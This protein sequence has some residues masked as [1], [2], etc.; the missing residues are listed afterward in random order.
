[1]AKVPSFLLGA[2]QL[3]NPRREP[4]RKIS[5]GEWKNVLSN[6]S[7]ARLALALRQEC[8]NE[9]PEWVR[10][11]I[12]N[13]LSATALRFE[14][15]KAVY[16][17]VGKALREENADHLVVKGFSLWPGYAEDPRFRPQGDIDLYCPP[18]SVHRAQNVLAMLDYQPNVRQEH[19]AKD[20]LCTM[21]PKGC[22]EWRGS[23]FDP[24][25]PICFELH[26]CFWNKGTMGLNPS[27]LDQFWNR[28]IIRCI[29]DFSFSGLE[30]VDNLGYTALNVVR[31]LFWGLPGPEQV[32]G[33][34]RF[35]HTQST[36]LGFWGR[37]RELHCDSLRQ[38]ET[39]SFRLASD[40][41][42]CRLP[43]EVQE[44][45]DRQPH[46]V[47]TWF[48]EFS[49][50]GINTPFY[51]EKDAVW[52]HLQLLDSI[53]AKSRA[54]VRGLLS[55]PARFPTLASVLGDDVQTSNLKGRKG[56]S[57]VPRLC[58]RLIAY[59]GWFVHRSAIRCAKVP[60]F[61]WRGLNFRRSAINLGRQF[62][63]F[64]AAAFCFDLGMT[65]FFFLYN[66]YLLDR[67]FKEDFLGTVASTMSLGSIACT[68]PAGMLVQRV[69]LRK[70][71]LFCLVLV[72][73]VSAAR[74]ALVPQWALLAFAFLGGFALTIWAVALSPAITRLTNEKSRPVA[75][76][77]VFSSGIGIG[78]VANLIASRIPGWL[79]HVS[80][81]GNA[82][83]AKRLALFAGCA[84]VA[85]GLLPAW[86]LHFE[87]IPSANKTLYPR[88][89]FL[90]R[91]LPALALW[92][93]VTASLSPLANVYFSKHLG[94]PLHRI[95]TVFS[96][97]SLFQVLAVLAAPFIFRRLG[98]VS[99]VASTQL[100]AA[101]MLT[102]LA[103]TSAGTSSA[104]LYVAYTGFLWMSEPG[105]FSLLM[106]R[107]APKEQAGAS[108]LN[109]LVISS[110]QAIAVAA[111]GFSFARFGYPAALRVMAGLA[112]ASAV[113][114]RLTLGKQ[115]LALTHSSA[116]EFS[117]PVA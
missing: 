71:L 55:A 98:L 62:W 53:G 90:L 11:R 66:L 1:M 86:C 50:S 107:V 41:F 80:L 17:N 81:L 30:A 103:A 70:S 6:W 115:D 54:L 73:S 49:R 9:L 74:A 110:V 112:L 13:H 20:H 15:I 39:I 12:D 94:M 91:F 36:D 68:L 104:V 34:A 95:G 26:F 46:G 57:E 51:R 61:L 102:C 113:V 28:R 77:I 18:E 106:S 78:I 67:G 76:S 88:N 75:F 21:M 29:D 3:R 33:L 43:E 99:G 24:E 42:G 22:R 56:P 84:I 65:I 85:L 7:T 48:R 105:L 45:I 32:Y 8:G 27:G 60:F 23:F 25:M 96:F 44:E 111:T 93:F 5:D 108:S 114:F 35:L 72:T 4:L 87:S 16:W 89:P 19:L 92:T 37:W 14:R 116:T 117:R 83:Q 52:L 101:I 2:L 79:M 47:H 100:A 69:G 38:L 10:A 64:L 40:W 63:M 97:A 59:V 31:D 109:F 58:L 82:I